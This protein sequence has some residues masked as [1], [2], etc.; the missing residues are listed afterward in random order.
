M[1]TGIEI[2]GKHSYRDFGALLARRS[3]DYPEEQQITETVPYSNIEYDFT[4]LYGERILM[5]RNV[6]YRFKFVN[7]D[8]TV[9][10]EDV[11]RFVKFMFSLTAD[12]SIYEDDYPRFHW[13]GK[14]TTIK[15][16]EDTVGHELGAR[17]VEVTFHC[18]PYRVSNRGDSF[19]AD[20]TKFPDI[21]GD[22]SVTAADAT[23][24]ATAAANIGAGEPSGLPV[25]PEV[26]GRTIEEQE[27]RADADR[28]GEINAV[29][30][31]FVL[32]FA[33]AVG[34][35]DYEDTPEGWA[36]FLNDSFGIEEEVL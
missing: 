19:P 17:M 16:I 27:I 26:P 3:M 18:E 10:E 28:N 22:G 34:A 35:G 15:N 30:A 24:I 9:N 25:D 7:P 1:I 32:S 2:N 14:R 4:D 5:R 21:D 13:V 31:Q 8:S 11:E 33:S 23:L 12:V 36:K 6:V 20:V 29:D